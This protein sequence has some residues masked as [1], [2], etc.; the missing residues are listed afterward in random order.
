[1]LN[2]PK[3]RSAVRIQPLP[4]A[5]CGPGADTWLER[6]SKTGPCPEHLQSLDHR[7]GAGF[8]QEEFQLS[9]LI[10]R[11]NSCYWFLL[12]EGNAFFSPLDSMKIFKYAIRSDVYNP[13]LKSISLSSRLYVCKKRSKI[14]LFCFSN[15]SRRLFLSKAFIRDD[16]RLYQLRRWGQNAR[17]GL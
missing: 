4:F 3:Q 13:N 10:K 17:T 11:R 5:W 12:V 16:L 8:K 6:P 1:M 9:K 2:Y 14:V 7:D 15:L